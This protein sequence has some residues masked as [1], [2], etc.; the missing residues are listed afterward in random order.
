MR[1]GVGWGS[2]GTV[3]PVADTDPLAAGLAT[4]LEWNAERRRNFAAI[5]QLTGAGAEAAERDPAT[6]IPRL[7][8]YVEALPLAEFEADDWF[9]L[10]TDLATFLGRLAAVR[11]AAYW[12]VR[13][14]PS[15]PRGYRYVV[16]TADGRAADPYE[17]VALEFQ[18]DVVDVV[19]MIATVEATLDAAVTG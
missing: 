16:A 10:Q 9:T 5:V 18:E 11:R 8:R 4:L 17:I 2:Q 1:A 3:S 15:T 19:R 14:A 12:G 6:L 13:A 7:Q